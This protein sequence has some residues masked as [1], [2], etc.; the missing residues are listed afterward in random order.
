MRRAREDQG[1]T[2]FNDLHAT[3]GIDAVREQLNLQRLMS[4][5]PAIMREGQTLAISE[6]DRE[7]AAQLAAIRELARGSCRGW[8][9]R[10][11]LVAAAAAGARIPLQGL[12]AARRPVRAPGST[13]CSAAATL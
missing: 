4:E 3:S 1:W 5:T 7:I 13:S 6:E 8:R 2:D 12:T 11:R 9:R 10:R